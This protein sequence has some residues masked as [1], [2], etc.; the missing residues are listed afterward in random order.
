[1]RARDDVAAKWRWFFAGVLAGELLCVLT[2]HFLTSPGVGLN[3]LVVAVTSFA[4]ALLV[5][6]NALV[7]S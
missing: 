5:A 3:W 7:R 6:F 4:L 2:L 1:M